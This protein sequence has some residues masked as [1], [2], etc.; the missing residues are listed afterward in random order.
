MIGEGGPD[1]EL[2]EKKASRQEASSIEAGA[3]AGG[4]EGN[5]GARRP[6]MRQLLCALVVAMAA[7]CASRQL[8]AVREFQ[9]AREAGDR[10]GA[11]R[12]MAPEA[13]SWFE[14]KEGEGDSWTLSGPWYEWDEEFG[15]RYAYGPPEEGPG[16]VRFEAREDNGFYRL[17]ERAPT[18]ARITYY[19]DDAGR[20][21][22]T[23]YE[24]IKEQGRPPDRFGEFKAWAREKRPGELER[25]MPE[26]QIKPG[27]EEARRWRA[28]LMEWRREAGLPAVEG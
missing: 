21:S 8:R 6:A 2:P 5:H 16:W 15:T 14:K 27:R 20:M 7:G 22:G 12:L 11:L 26:G 24:P 19:V 10:E 4:G 13:R 23:L 9:S 28:L 1:L 3:S 18:K 25:L 17:I